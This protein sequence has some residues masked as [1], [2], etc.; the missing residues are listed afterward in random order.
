MGTNN[1]ENHLLAKEDIVKQLAALK[2]KLAGDGLSPEAVKRHVTVR[3]V[4]AKLRQVNGRLAAVDQ[5][6]KQNKKRQ[7]E[8][9]KKAK[10]KEKAKADALKADSGEKKD[11]PQEGE[12]KAPAG[13]KK[14]KKAKP[15]ADKKAAPE[16]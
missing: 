16:S 4:G 10:A 12:G 1:R 15:K 7:S 8:K 2:A 6:E 9:V 14:G 3:Q 11:K 5:L 13:D